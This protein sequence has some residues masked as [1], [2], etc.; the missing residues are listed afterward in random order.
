MQYF[1]FLA[2]IPFRIQDINQISYAMMKYIIIDF[3][4][5]PIF[6]FLNSHKISAL[7]LILFL[8]LHFI[9]FR[10][11]EIAK[12]ISEM[13]NKRWFLILLSMCLAI[14]IFHQGNPENF[15]YFKF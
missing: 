5:Q 12:K 6:I 15:I 4:V 3:Q 1:V 11:G 14:L 8:I 7:L 13:N 2:W 9:V 10:K